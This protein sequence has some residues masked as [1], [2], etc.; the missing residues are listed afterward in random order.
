MAYTS[1]FDLNEGLNYTEP[2]IDEYSAATAKI[3]SDIGLELTN[4]QRATAA[5]AYLNSDSQRR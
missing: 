3:F 1:L 5:I 2:E 4:N